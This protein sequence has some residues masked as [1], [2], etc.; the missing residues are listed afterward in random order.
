MEIGSKLIIKKIEPQ[1]TKDGKEFLSVILL[2]K[3]YNIKRPFANK[4]ETA[5]YKAQL[6]TDLPVEE[7]QFDLDISKDKYSVQN[8]SNPEKSIIRIT[9]FKFEKVT[10]WKG[11]MQLKTDLNQPIMNDKFYITGCE[12]DKVGWKSN[13]RIIKDQK[14]KIEEQKQLIKE[15][16]NEIKRLKHTIDTLNANLSR[17]SRAKTEESKKVDNLLAE[18]EKP[19]RNEINDLFGLGEV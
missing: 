15:Q 16:K 3:V 10:A 11:Q 12:F 8:I 2:E 6:F 17:S 19:V 18:E 1:I 5:Q 4:W 9:D 7:A 14:D 13:E